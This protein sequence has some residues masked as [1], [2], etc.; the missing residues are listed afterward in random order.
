M[1]RF[2]WAYTNYP[3]HSFATHRD[4]AAGAAAKASS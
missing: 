4:W 2:P 3:E 1:R